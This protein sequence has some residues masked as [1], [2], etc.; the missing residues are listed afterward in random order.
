[1]SGNHE[2]WSSSYQT[3]IS[4]LEDAQVTIL[5]N[6]AVQIKRGEEYIS[7]LGVSD[8]TFG[9]DVDEVLKAHEVTTFQILLSHRPELFE[10]YVNRSMDL[11][12]SGH[13][14]GGQ[15]RLPFVGNGLVAPNQGLFPKYS[16]GLHI[17]KDTTMVVSRGLGNSIVPLR[18]FNQP[19]IVCA[20]L[21]GK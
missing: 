8:P 17:K 9:T 20:T 7:L 16:E 15:F 3:L 1:M 5:N 19:E 6:E 21:R 14:H 13:A 4:A 11:V 2:A 18:L 12:F 10:M